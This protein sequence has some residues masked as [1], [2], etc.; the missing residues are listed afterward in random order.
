[1]TLTTFAFSANERPTTSFIRPSISLHEGQGDV[2]SIPDL[3]DFHAKFNPHHT[4][5]I[6]AQKTE[7]GD[8][9]SFLDV[10]YSMLKQAILRCQEWLHETVA[11]LQL[12]LPLPQED[13]D[14]QHH[15]RSVVK[16]APIAIFM[17]SNVGLVIYIFALMGLCVPVVLFSTRLSSEA[18]KHLLRR[19]RT[20]AILVSSRLRSIAEEALALWDEDE[21]NGND[22]VNGQ[23]NIP[24]PVQYSPA[25]YEEFLTPISSSSSSG[26]RGDVSPPSQ[27]YVSATDCDV[28]ILH[29]SGTTGLPKPIYTSHR[30]YLSFALCHEFTNDEQMLSPTLSTSP[31]FHVSLRT[32]SHIYLR[33]NTLN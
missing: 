21:S 31:L 30:H 32:S 25:S 13:E 17:D 5:C 24:L 10:T 16:G 20:R 19:T 18:V 6:Q 23:E 3:V 15:R 33:S 27:H 22:A 4:F 2:Q 28:L 11:E 14:E 9:P 7:S 8:D 26:M 1:M 12:P 29:S